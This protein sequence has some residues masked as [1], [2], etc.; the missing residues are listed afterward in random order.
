M[1]AGEPEAAAEE[2]SAEAAAEEHADGTQ[3]EPEQAAEGEESP[4]P[5]EQKE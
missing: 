3:P 5:A 4:E 2:L 1:D